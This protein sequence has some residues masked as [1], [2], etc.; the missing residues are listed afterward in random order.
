MN[1]PAG[2][3]Y[4]VR[5][6]GDP[7]TKMSAVKTYLDAADTKPIAGAPGTVYRDPNDPSHILFSNPPAG[8]STT[9]KID[10]G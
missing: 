7:S 9:V 8:P 4:F 3:N 1:T 2:Q 10:N 5:A 6:A